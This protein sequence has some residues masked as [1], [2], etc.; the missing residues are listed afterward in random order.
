[1]E[2]VVEKETY[3]DTDE[4]KKTERNTEAEVVL[5]ESE[6]S[7]VRTSTSTITEQNDADI[8]RGSNHLFEMEASV[9]S[10]VITEEKEKKEEEKEENGKE[11][12]KEKKKEKEREEK[13]KE[14]EE[15][16]EEEEGEEEEEAK[17]RKVCTQTLALIWNNILR[18][19]RT[20]FSTLIEL[21][22][23][24]ALMWLLVVGYDLSDI[25]SK[26]ARSYNFIRVDIPGPFESFF[27]GIGT[28]MVDGATSNLLDLLGLRNLDLVPNLDL[29]N[30]NGIVDNI[31]LDN[32]TGI[33]NGMLTELGFG[34]DNFTGT[35]D[36]TSFNPNPNLDNFA[37]IFNEMSADLGLD[38]FNGTLNGFDTI[39]DDGARNRSDS[40]VGEF[41]EN[42]TSTLLNGIMDIMDGPLP[43]PTLD[44]F[45][46]LSGLLKQVIKL[47]ELDYFV[48]ESGYLKKW[49]TLLNPDGP[50]TIHITTRGGGSNGGVGKGLAEEFVSYLNDTQL[51]RMRVLRNG[52]KDRDD[53]GTS[54]DSETTGVVYVRVRIHDD[55]DAA[56]EYV[57]D[58]LDEK[59]FVLIELEENQNNG[60]D[61]EVVS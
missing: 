19:S 32:F 50:G 37:G 28:R 61:F 58:N 33:I 36:Q 41:T 59:T 22:M 45:L 42:Q 24:V 20:P 8:S 30:F 13:E 31:D 4:G 38:T 2:T 7:A 3:V 14:E 26:D 54:E 5:R 39:A 6:V 11:K 55:A 40:I 47:D 25:V 21:F 29:N 15:E 1:M 23:P 27:D 57:M 16:E 34:L 56:V 52:D 17:Q 9:E 49:D 10:G 43:I 48:R 18:K 60:E 51:L 12:E 35:F 46:L 44:Q 53:D